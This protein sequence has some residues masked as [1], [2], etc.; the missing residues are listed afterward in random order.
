MNS[1]LQGSNSIQDILYGVMSSHGII[2]HVYRYRSKV[3]TRVLYILE[4]QHSC[5]VYVYLNQGLHKFVLGNQSALVA[6]AGLGCGIVGV[7]ETWSLV[8]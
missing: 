4:K 8:Y 1:K 5:L 3:S 7:F 6:V 2:V